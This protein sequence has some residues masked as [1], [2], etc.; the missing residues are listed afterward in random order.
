MFILKSNK[1]IVVGVFILF[2]TFSALGYADDVTDSI[3]EALQYYKDGKYPDAVGSLNYAAQLIQQKKGNELRAFL[4]KPLSGWAADDATTQTA[5]ASMFGGGIATERQY[6]K[7]PSSVT[8][9]I[10]TDS[11]IMQGMMMMFSNPMFAGAEGGQLERIGSQKAIVKFDSADKRGDIK[12]IVANRFLVS[13]EGDEVAKT[14][15]INYAKA[16]DYKK[17]ATLP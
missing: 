14:D 4:P 11:P 6:H 7:G 17:M 13:I 15:L 8:V 9:Q 10:V 16:I 12:I 1:L 3:T 2:M 5:A